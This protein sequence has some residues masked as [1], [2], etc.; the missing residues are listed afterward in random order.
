M[1]EKSSKK[2][3]ILHRAMVLARTGGVEAVTARAVCQAAGV[4]APTLYYHFGDQQGLREAIVT[5]AFQAALAKTSTERDE[6]PTREIARG[7]DAYVAFAMTEPRIFAIMNASIVSDRVP[8]IALG[9]LATLESE[10]EKLTS[11]QLAGRL[12]GDLGYRD[13][14]SRA[15]CRDNGRSSSARWAGV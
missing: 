3:E 15:R 14:V 11:V 12:P 13:V 7:W 2:A 10:F 4:T 1:T 9:A 8:D 5:A 6:D